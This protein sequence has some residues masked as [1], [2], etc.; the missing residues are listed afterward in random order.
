[1]RPAPLGKSFRGFAYI[2]PARL[3]ATDLVH[4]L[5]VTIL[6]ARLVAFIHRQ[7]TDEVPAR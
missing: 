5:P 6:T 4:A 7:E 1:M 3:V 2:I